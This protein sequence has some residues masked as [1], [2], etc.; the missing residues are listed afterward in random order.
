M[1]ISSR[2]PEGTPHRCP[3]C[4]H[5]LRV[6]P[7]LF[8]GDAPCPRCGTLLW[9]VQLGD[10]PRFFDWAETVELRERLMEALGGLEKMNADS[11]DVMEIGL[12]VE[13]LEQ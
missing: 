13:E 1:T 7:S 2:T 5:G 9:F 8:F 11:L 3:V 10:D 4:G 6:E 12:E